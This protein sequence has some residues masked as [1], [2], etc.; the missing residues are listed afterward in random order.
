MQIVG[1]SLLAMPIRNRLSLD[2]LGTLSHSTPAQGHPEPVERMSL[3]NVQA[4]SYGNHRTV[5]FPKKEGR[6]HCIDPA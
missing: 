3:S 2:T 6:V 1:A 4:G 5:F